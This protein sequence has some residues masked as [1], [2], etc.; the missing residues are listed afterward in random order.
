MYKYAVRVSG[1]RLN[2][3]E[4][5]GRGFMV[6]DRKQLTLDKLS[7][8]LGAKIR[9][10]RTQRNL[11]ITDLADM[12]G[13]TSS[14]ISQLERALASPSI[15]TLKKICDA[16]DVPIA[17]LFEEAQTAENG[18]HFTDREDLTTTVSP[19]A[20]QI[21]FEAYLKLFPPVNLGG[22]SPVVT[23]KNRK[24]LFPSKGIRYYLLTPDL[25]GPIEFILNEHDPGASTGWHFHIGSECGLVLSGELIVEVKDK[26][27]T[28]KKGDSIILNSSDPHLKRND[29]DEMCSSVWANVPPWF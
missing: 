16:L 9:S 22:A 25:S 11:K 10:L 17:Y 14:L 8:S 26:V 20:P 2:I 12:T 28:L 27:Y 19:S 23:E 7:L 15:S 24:F 3:I 18:D 4:I 1:P 5:R 13:L 21:D 29:S 6:N